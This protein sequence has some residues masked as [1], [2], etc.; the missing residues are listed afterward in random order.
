[1]YWLTEYVHTGEK[2]IMATATTTKALGLRVNSSAT[3]DEALATIREALDRE[4]QAIL[5]AGKDV[6]SKSLARRRCV[7]AAFEQLASY[8]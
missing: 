7:D 1:M 6:P 8:S 3:T 5:Q 2:E 4:I